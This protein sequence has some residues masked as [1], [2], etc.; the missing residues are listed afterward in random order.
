MSK[1]IILM[2]LVLFVSTL[3]LSACFPKKSAQQEAVDSMMAQSD[4]GI[5]SGS[6]KQLMGLGKAQKC[7]WEGE[8]GESG[9]V[10][11]DGTRSRFEASGYSMMGD[12]QEENSEL[13]TFFGINDDEYIYTWSSQSNEGMKM[14][15]E[16]EEEQQEMDEYDSEDYDSSMD[17]R[18]MS[19][20]DFEYKC[21]DWSVD[22]SMFVPPTNIEFT[23][24]GQ[25]IESMKDSMKG[26]ESMC[27]SLE[28]QAK[29]DCLES[30][31]QL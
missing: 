11:T 18:S 20:Y 16:T 17:Y 25:M 30:F 31:E 2:A 27:D 15:N 28:G 9:V 29:T 23:D 8:A 3:A 6:L 22:E 4:D 12:D 19:E 26:M 21:E 10:Y 7:T 13:V 1:K 24:F 14:S 5:F